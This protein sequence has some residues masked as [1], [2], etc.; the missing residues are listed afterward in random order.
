MLIFYIVGLVGILF[1][2]QSDAAYSVL[3]AWQSVGLV[4]GFICAQFLSLKG[5][6]YVTMA[7]LVIA[8]VSDLILEFRTQ[9]KEMLLPWFLRPTIKSSVVS[10][11]QQGDQDESGL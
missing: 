3:R 6:C 5:R 1:S 11:P 7:A 4:M 10:E 2:G 8:L 9:P